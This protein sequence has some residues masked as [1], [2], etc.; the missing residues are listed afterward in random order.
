M[1]LYHELAEY[2]FAIENN[3]RDIAHDAAFITGLLAGKKSPALL[4]LGCGTGEHLGLLAKAGIRC[5]GIDISEE[6][7]LAARKR[8]PDG[9]DLYRSDMQEISFKNAF[10]AIVCLFGSFNYLIFDADIEAML[11]RVR[12]ALKPG[13]IGVFEI[14]NSPPIRK[15]REKDVSPVSL[16]DFRGTN[17]RRERGFRMR[18]DIGRT[19]VEVT[20]RY[21][22][23]E[24]E[25]RTI[26]FDRHVMRS[27][28]PEEF[29][30]FLLDAGFTVKSIFANFLSEPYEE[31]SNRMVVVFERR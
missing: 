9:I 24:G 12:A 11:G 5:T 23:E 19:V 27:F 26:V 7:I 20:Y 2:Y 21:T 8:L 18:D 4:D 6:M 17:I 1:K 28:T 13:G 30:R 29:S 3:H 10:D 16:T 31:N 15:I 22:I 25:D 14:W